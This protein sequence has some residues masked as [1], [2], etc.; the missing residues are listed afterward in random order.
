MADINML[1]GRTIASIYADDEI[2]HITCEDGSSFRFI[3]H[4]DCCESVYIESINGDLQSLVGNPILIAEARSN[5]APP[6]PDSD[7]SYT[8]TFYT[9]ATIK[10]HVDIRWYGTSNGYYS[11]SVDFEYL[12]PDKVRP[13]RWSSG[14]RIPAGYGV[15][16]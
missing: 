15:W 14:T 16:E 4:Q 9:L 1:V 5:D 10:G 2:I 7:V 6:L 12:N 13:G 8:W 11:E 3:H